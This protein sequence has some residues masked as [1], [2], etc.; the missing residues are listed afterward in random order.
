[1]ADGKRPARVGPEFIS[2]DDYH[3]LIEMLCVS[4]ERL[5]DASIEIASRLDALYDER[6]FVLDG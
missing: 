5:D 4:A 3:G 6:K 1:V 2:I